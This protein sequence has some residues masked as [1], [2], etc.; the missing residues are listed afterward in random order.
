MVVALMPNSAKVE[1]LL[2]CNGVSVSDGSPDLGH[3]NPDNLAVSFVYFVLNLSLLRTSDAVPKR[4]IEK[5]W[6][7]LFQ[8]YCN[9][10]FKESVD[11][12]EVTIITREKLENVL[13]ILFCC[14][15]GG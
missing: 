7:G 15:I 5:W 9:V 8:F 2:F 10:C 12:R 13:L 4:N 6:R 11:K 1:T 14:K 3:S